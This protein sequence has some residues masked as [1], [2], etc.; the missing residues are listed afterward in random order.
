[1]LCLFYFRFS[2]FALPESPSN[3]FCKTPF[4][5]T[6]GLLKHIDV[7]SEAVQIALGAQ[8]EEKTVL[9]KKTKRRLKKKFKNSK[10]AIKAPTRSNDKEKMYICSICNTKKYKYRRNKMR[11]EKYE[12]VTG[13]QFVCDQCE[14]KYSQKK[15]LTMHMGHKHPE[16]LCTGGTDGKTE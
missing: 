15:S 16:M 3:P 10:K 9:R 6:R 5:F 1:M 14:R 7:Q 12:C 2:L 13:P 11:H 4:P 8:I